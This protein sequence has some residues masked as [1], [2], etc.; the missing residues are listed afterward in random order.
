ML[1]TLPSSPLSALTNNS[2]QQTFISNCGLMEHPITKNVLSK[3]FKKVN[4]E[5]IAEKTMSRADIGHM[6]KSKAD[7]TFRRPEFMEALFVVARKKFKGKYGDDPSM[8]FDALMTQFIVPH[9]QALVAE[10]FKNILVEE[11]NAAIITWVLAKAERRQTSY[12]C[13]PFHITHPPNRS[14]I[15][16][17]RDV[18]NKFTNVD[19]GDAHDIN[20]STTISLSEFEK[21]FVDARMM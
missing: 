11:A 6:G 14:N 12:L 4:E 10:D 9:V 16:L 19:E 7:S 15:E 3:I 18:Y 20:D 2:N 17:L 1:R 8:Q 21:I 5:L 13:I